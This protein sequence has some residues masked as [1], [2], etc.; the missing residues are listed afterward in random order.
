MHPAELAYPCCLP[1]LGEFRKITPHEGSGSS[2]RGVR[3]G[4]FLDALLAR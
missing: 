2:V 1:A 3:S 4:C